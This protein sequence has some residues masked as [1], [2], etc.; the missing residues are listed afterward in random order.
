MDANDKQIKIE[1]KKRCGGEVG[2]ILCFLDTQQQQQRQLY[3]HNGAGI[4]PACVQWYVCREDTRLLI[5]SHYY[6]ALSPSSHSLSLSL[7]LSLS[8][9][10]TKAVCV[11]FAMGLRINI[12]SA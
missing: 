7:S 8:P 9:F 10:F 5:S 11:W 4:P 3:C 2:L 1:N 12:K 6:P